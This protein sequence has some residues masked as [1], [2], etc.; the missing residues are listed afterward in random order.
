MKEISLC[1]NCYC[2]TKNIKQGNSNIYKCGKCGYFKSEETSNHNK[3]K[4]NK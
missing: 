4:V 2:M 1:K 3:T